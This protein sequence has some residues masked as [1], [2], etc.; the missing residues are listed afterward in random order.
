MQEVIKRFTVKYS[1][2]FSEFSNL[3]YGGLYPWISASKS[4]IDAVQQR[5]S[6]DEDFKTMMNAFRDEFYKV[7]GEANAV[8]DGKLNKL[9]NE[10]Q[11]KSSIQMKIAKYLAAVSPVADYIYVA[12]D[13]T[14]TGLRSLEYFEQSAQNFI[15]TFNSYITA[16]QN[17]AEAKDSTFTVNSF[18]NVKDRP[19]FEFQEEPLKEKL[20]AVLPYWS[21]LIFFNI[22]F[23]TVAYE[24]FLRYDVR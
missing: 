21:V 15:A 4:D 19:R 22:L 7:A 23:F 10:M 9:K 2:T 14:G 3:K 5:A 11:R 1:K 8:M 20:S 12:T 18:L 13:L 16:K 17:E 6:A 24:L